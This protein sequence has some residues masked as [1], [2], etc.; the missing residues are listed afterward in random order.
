MGTTQPPH[1]DDLFQAIER[2]A[3]EPVTEDREPMAPDHPEA[4]DS[5]SFLDRML[6]DVDLA[7]EMAGLFLGS[8]PELMNT[9]RQALN[10][11]DT[12]TLTDAAQALKGSARI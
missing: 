10:R 8:S 2:L 6:G 9:L 3:P 4:F 7:K 12:K 5:Q 1:L 11:R